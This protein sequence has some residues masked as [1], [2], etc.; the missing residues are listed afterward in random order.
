MPPPSLDGAEAATTHRPSSSLNSR[1]T[2]EDCVS[3]AP[4]PTLRDPVIH[5]RRSGRYAPGTNPPRYS[6]KMMDTAP[7]ATT[8]LRSCS[9][10]IKPRGS[11][12]SALAAISRACARVSSSA[13]SRAYRVAAAKTSCSISC[14]R[15]G[16]CNRLRRS[17]G[18][19]R[20]QISTGLGPGS[21]MV[22]TMCSFGSKARSVAAISRPQF[23]GGTP[24]SMNATRN[25]CPRST[26]WRTASIVA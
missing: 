20:S 24:I 5:E 2:P 26:A 17:A 25:D 11:S 9:A 14:A 15:A 1:T 21:A 7:V 12:V 10:T 16:L 8:I 22:S 23:P 13:R 3:Q 18:G 19:I 6:G 4:G